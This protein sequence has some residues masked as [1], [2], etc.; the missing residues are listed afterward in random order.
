MRYDK[1]TV[2]GY[3]V[4]E[5]DTLKKVVAARS[6]AVKAST[7]KEAIE[8]E[9]EFVGTLGRLIAISESYPELKSDKNFMELQR[10]MFPTN[11]VAGLFG[12]KEEKFFEAF[13][14]E[15]ENVSVKF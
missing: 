9:Q 4:H 3:A 5:Q 2:K 11:I 15:R 7:A 8:A 6:A 10:E 1:E 14:E 12:F 13:S